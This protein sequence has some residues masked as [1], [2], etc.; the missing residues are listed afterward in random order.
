MCVCVC[1][2]ILELD[3]IPQLEKL[4]LLVIFKHYGVPQ[5]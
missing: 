1:V 2:D 4:Q 5:D 3:L